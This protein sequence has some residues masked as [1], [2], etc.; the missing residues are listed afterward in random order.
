MA[1][2][3]TRLAAVATRLISENGR[4]ITLRRAS[5]DPDDP[6]K[7]WGTADTTPAVAG[8]AD[9]VQAITTTGVF[10]DPERTDRPLGLVEWKKARVLVPPDTNIPEEMGPDWVVDDGSRRFEIEESRPVKPGGTLMYY[11]LMVST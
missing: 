2:D 6:T 9:G 8:S 4:A 7:P 5:R 1:L 11:E 10:L 3:Y